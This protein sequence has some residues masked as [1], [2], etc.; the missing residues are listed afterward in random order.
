MWL[1]HVETLKILFPRI[2]LWHEIM[3]FTWLIDYHE[4]IKFY[5]ILKF[6][7]NDSL[8]FPTVDVW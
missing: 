7:R 4:Y 3:N 2:F 8:A 6:A 1:R 5:T